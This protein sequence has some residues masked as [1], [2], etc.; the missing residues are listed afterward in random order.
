M[1]TPSKKNKPKA[2]TSSVQRIKAVVRKLPPNLPEEIFW[3]SCELW[4]NDNT[5]KERWYRPGRT[6]AGGQGTGNIMSRAYIAFRTAEE[7]ATF[8]QNY[9]GHLF[10]DKQG[11]EYSAVVEF[12]PSQKLP[13]ANQKADARQGTIEDDE[14]YKSFVSLIEK[15]ETPSKDKAP[16]TVLNDASKSESTPLL[17]ALIHSKAG[18]GGGKAHK[19]KQAHAQQ[20]K[21]SKAADDIHFSRAQ[22]IVPSGPVTL[23]TANKAESSKTP[24]K[25]PQSPTAP[26]SPPSQAQDIPG[27]GRGKGRSTAPSQQPT[28]PAKNPKGKGGKRVVS[29]G[30]VKNVATSEQ[31]NENKVDNTPTKPSTSGKKKRGHIP[32]SDGPSKSDKNN[33]DAEPRDTSGKNEPR[34]SGRGRGRGRG[35]V[36]VVPKILTKIIAEGST[37]PPARGGSRTTSTTEKNA[38]TQPQALP[39]ANTSTTAPAVPPAAN[40]TPVTPSQAPEK[41]EAVD[42]SED[43]SQKQ[44]SSS[45]R[46]GT[47]DQRGFRLPVE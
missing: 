28:S 23:L 35:G 4:V 3:R 14:D 41:S 26:K 19:Q 40:P 21:S 24:A 30:D 34:D 5:V 16:A 10:R 8:S 42:A 1:S 38:D 44:S 36:V 7:L 2:S 17:E 6:K 27:K 22:P 37:N 43:G 33:D 39:S 18:S 13:S 29:E 31:A 15:G 47:S 45:T 20:S 46:G 11:N 9:D 25:A 12:A 32:A